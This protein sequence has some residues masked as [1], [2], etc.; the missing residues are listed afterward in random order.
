MRTRRISAMV[1]VLAYNVRDG[2]FKSSK[3]KGGS[4]DPNNYRPISVTSLVCKVFETIIKDQL[5]SYLHTHSFISPSQHGFLRSHST[6]TNL[7][8]SLND[9]TES[10]EGNKTVKILYTDFS[11]AFD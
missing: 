11:K 6:V 10:I 7:I 3:L 5:V 8:E 4:S 1:R 9:W 2:E